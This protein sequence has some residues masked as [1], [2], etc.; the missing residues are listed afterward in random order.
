MVALDDGPAGR[1]PFEAALRLTKRAPGQQPVNGVLVC[2]HAA[3][4]VSPALRNRLQVA[5]YRFR[6][7][8][9]VL[10]TRPSAAL[11]LERLVGSS[12]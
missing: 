4:R 8:R 10:V 2:L 3:R 11:I 12:P 5:A 1:C 6:Q 7:Y 9:C